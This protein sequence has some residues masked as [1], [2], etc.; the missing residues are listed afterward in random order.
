MYEKPVSICRITT[1]TV[2][3][4]LSFVD[5][6]GTETLFFD[7]KCSKKDVFF[8]FRMSTVIKLKTK[9]KIALLTLKISYVH[10]KLWN[11]QTGTA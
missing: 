2:V 5:H 11:L 10:F 7:Y 8:K 9:T 3:V 4:L 1:N 6:R